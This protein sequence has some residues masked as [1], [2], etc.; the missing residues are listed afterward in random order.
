MKTKISNILLTLNALIL[1][2]LILAVV[3][4]EPVYITDNSPA[5]IYNGS[6]FES[7]Q[8]NENKIAVIFS[9]DSHSNYGEILVLEFDDESS[10]FN[11]S[12]SYDI[13]LGE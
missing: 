5:N 12:G 1:L 10:T 7:V 6:S 8:I 2:L 13:F 4:R 3:I 11:E 9:S